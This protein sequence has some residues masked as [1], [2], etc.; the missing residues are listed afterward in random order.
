M[1]NIISRPSWYLPDSAA[2]AESIYLNRRHFIK[3]LGLGA[4][5]M[6]VTARCGV[7]QP[8][9]VPRT[10]PSV[11]KLGPLPAYKTN[12]N[13]SDP[14]RPLTSLDD[15]RNPL[16]FNNFYEFGTRKYQP[17]ISA[18]GFTL[19]PYALEIGGL[20][21]EPVKLGLEDVEAL[22]V[23]E[24][25]YRF[26][27][28]EAWAMTVPWVGVPL[29]KILAKV[30][31]LP[32]AK[33]VAFQTFLDPERAS[34]QKAQNYDWPYK[35]G[36][37]L[38][39]AMNEMTMAVTGMYGKRLLPQSGTPLRIIA[40]WKYGY[41]GAKSVVKITLIAGQPATL[42]NTALA[43]EYKFYSNV[44]PEV[45]HPRWSQ[46]SEKMLS[47]LSPPES[48]PTQWYNGYGEQVGAMY[49]DMKRVLY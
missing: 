35:E 2:I 23:E 22:G 44:D 1:P 12:P 7:A 15:E 17:A 4:A 20:V 6:A 5:A 39:E 32:E 21:K 25:V 19:D 40:P 18:R 49:A 48:V 46:A 11:E 3:A 43:S 9:S 31:I 28:V 33:Y 41:K 42:W 24:R 34:G 13:F 45:P 37:R 26:R 14:G 8:I 29:A 16:A 36:L 10:D 47:D 27:C 38:D 30:D